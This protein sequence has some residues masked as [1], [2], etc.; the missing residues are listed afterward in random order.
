MGLAQ[1]R[2]TFYCKIPYKTFRG[3]VF[4]P[5]AETLLMHSKSSKY[6]EDFPRKI[7]SFVS[8]SIKT[9]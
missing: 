5:L 3:F 2:E 7:H 6:G 4:V 9:E 8:L 1:K